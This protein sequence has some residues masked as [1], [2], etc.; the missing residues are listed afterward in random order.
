LS[1]IL[2]LEGQSVP[3]GFCSMQQVQKQLIWFSTS[4]TKLLASYSCLLYGSP[5]AR[6]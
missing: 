5:M 2:L 6:N 1:Q 3:I 4:F